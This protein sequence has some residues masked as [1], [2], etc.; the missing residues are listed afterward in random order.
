[1]LDSGTST[2][3]NFMGNSLHFEADFWKYNETRRIQEEKSFEIISRYFSINGNLTREYKTLVKSEIDKL[4]I[5]YMAKK[6]RQ[7]HANMIFSLSL[8]PF[9]MWTR[10]AVNGVIYL[11]TF[12]H[13][14]PY[15][16][17]SVHGVPSAS[18]RICLTALSQK[19][20]F[21]KVRHRNQVLRL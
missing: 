10:P 11:M 12:R 3:L 14:R 2:T 6:K 16:T 5:L 18:S 13:G 20:D 21:R 19:C 9:Y 15:I 1:M 8:M 4:L 7:G 17:I